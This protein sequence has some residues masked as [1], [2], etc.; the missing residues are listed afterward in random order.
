[1]TY[2]GLELFLLLFFVGS[3]IIVEALSYARGK[4]RPMVAVINVAF[5][6][7]ACLVLGAIL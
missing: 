2:T 3:A 6:A 4:T 1:V 7:V 5:V